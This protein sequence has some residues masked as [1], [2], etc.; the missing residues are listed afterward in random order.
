MNL[1]TLIRVYITISKP[2]FEHSI[3]III[4]WN[5]QFIQQNMFIMVDI[6]SFMEFNKCNNDSI[7]NII[8]KRL[9]EYYVCVFIMNCNYYYYNY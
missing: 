6:L 8:K 2:F 7:Y 5:F 4:R 1:S 3:I 9:L